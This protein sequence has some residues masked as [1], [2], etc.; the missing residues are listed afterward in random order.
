MTNYNLAQ[1]TNSL[2]RLRQ[3][4]PQIDDESKKAAFFIINRF[5]C[6]KYPMNAQFLNQK[7]FDEVSA[8]E[9][10]FLHQKATTKTPDWF[11]LKPASKKF[12]KDD[13]DILDQHINSFYK[14][15][16]ENDLEYYKEMLEGPITEKVKKEKKVKK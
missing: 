8:L 10:W 4:W 11:W 9:I 6:K 13:L 7:G 3:Q 15:E 2:F 16:I 1:V 14:E 12:S 5:L